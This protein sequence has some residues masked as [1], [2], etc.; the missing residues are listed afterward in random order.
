MS[1]DKFIKDLSKRIDKLREEREW[2]YQQMADACD[3][4]KAQVY[5]LCTKGTDLR[6]SSLAKIAKGFKLTLSA[7]MDF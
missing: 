1:D 3:M 6:G 4:D 2:S 5:K 7:L